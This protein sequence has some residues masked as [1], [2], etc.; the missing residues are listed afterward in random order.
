MEPISRRD[1]IREKFLTHLENFPEGKRFSELVTL[2]QANFPDYPLGTIT[3]SI[4]NLDAVWPD[5]VTKYSRGVWVLKKYVNEDLEA[6]IKNAEEKDKRIN[7]S[8]FYPA[9]KDYLLTQLQECSKAIELGGNIFRDKW[10]TPDV[11]GI[12]KPQPADILKFQ[13]EIVSVEV[14]TDCHALITAFGQ[15]CAYKLFSHKAYIAIPDESP[16]DDIERLESLCQIMGIG[17]L[18]FNRSNPDS[19]RIQIKCRAMKTN[20]DMFYVNKSIRYIADDLLG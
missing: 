5:R 6:D 2:L 7:E 17:L 8:A 14:K 4:W 16:V 1:Q 11:I 13:E 18:L 9:M 15:A 10:G 20:P 12:N 19:P 3:G